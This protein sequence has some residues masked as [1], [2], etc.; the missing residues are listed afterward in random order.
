MSE[1]SSKLEAVRIARET[2]GEVDAGAI[3]AHV[4]THFGLKMKPA[5]VTV[6]LA[7]LKERETLEQVRRKAQ[8]E[9]KKLRE[10]RGQD[11]KTPRK[12]AASSE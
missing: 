4:E 5:I 3:A 9:M 10:Q 6:L 7:S 2:L 8:A 11:E 12:K 1:Q